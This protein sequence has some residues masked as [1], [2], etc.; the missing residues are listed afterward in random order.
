MARALLAALD[1]GGVVCDLPCDFRSRDGK[2]DA[3]F[4]AARIAE[5]AALIPDIIAQGRDAGWQGWLTYHSYY[6][7]PDLIGPA[8]SNALGIPYFL[9][10]ATRARKRL[11]GPWD[12]YAQAAEAACDTADV[13]FFLT[14]HDEIALKSY[15]PAGQQLIHLRPFL[16][17]SELP[18]A[19]Q[20]TKTMLSVGMMRPG[21]KLAS[22]DLIAK[23]LAALS[24]DW[25]LEI[26]GD[27]PARPDV[28]L[29][30]APFGNRVKFLGQLDGDAM[31]AAYARACLLFWPGVNE[32]FGLTYL[33]AQARGV[34]V[35]AQDRPGVRDVLVPGQYPSPEAGVDGLVALL[36]STLAAP[37]NATSIRS[38]IA[39]HHLLPAARDTL[40][41]GFSKGGIS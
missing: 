3:A 12:A 35:V 8:V 14:Q 18:P 19:A 25:S 33:E 2:G 21:D 1:A 16:P 7:A 15:A 34:G 23:S 36:Q 5:A 13:I 28:E 22:Y 11:G 38:Y 32:A 24:G 40:C 6:K 27:G 10:E 41:A 26:A 37:P 4:Q 17:L 31:D 29:R 9:V 20:P 30:M 39:A